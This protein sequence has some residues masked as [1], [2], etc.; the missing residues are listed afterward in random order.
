MYDV[1]IKD[2]FCFID[3]NFIKA[4]IGVNANVIEYIGK[5]NIKGE[6]TIDASDKLVLPGLFNGHTHIAMC[7]FRGLAEDLPLDEW[8]KEKIWKIESKLKPGDVYYGSLLGILEMIKS[9][10]T[11][12]YDMYFYMDEVAKAVEE[13]KIRAVLSYGMADRGDKERGKKELKIGKNFFLKW[14]GGSSGRIKVILGPHAL[15]T[16]S[17]DFLKEVKF[18]ARKLNTMVHIHVS[19]TKKEV[20]EIF[21][22][23]GKLP[24]ELLDHIEFLDSNT[25]IAHAVWLNES[26]MKI[27]KKREVSVV[28]NPVS[29][30]KLASG[31]SRI[32][33]MLK[34]GINVCLGTD[35]GASNNS[36]NL[37]EEIKMSLLLQKYITG[38]ADA[39]KAHDA[40]LMATK[41]GYKAYK[42]NGGVLK[43]GFLAD[44]ILVEKSE[45]LIPIYNPVYSIAYS[46]YCKVT[47]SVIDGEI[48]MENGTVLTLNEEKI[49]KKAEKVASEI[50]N[51]LT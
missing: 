7:I 25:I 2:G 31:I 29:N 14:N 26:E 12:F 9:G 5:Q 50:L 34:Y 17:L 39:L 48:I 40:L 6:I 13:S 32:S 16:C 37:F 49:I 42:L 41:N 30:L 20:D 47:H 8:L 22:K 15:Y 23:Y 1:V 24:I 3:G 51:R 21:K 45:N 19:E 28:H 18:I 33:E 44:I 35:G 43:K 4:N 11:A 46:G 36:Y 10:T 27:L 38:R